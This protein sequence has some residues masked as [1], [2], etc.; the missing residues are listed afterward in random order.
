MQ[1]S[2]VKNVFKKLFIFCDLVAILDIFV[3][4]GISFV[5]KAF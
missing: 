4:F 3:W 5:T 2:D 1:E